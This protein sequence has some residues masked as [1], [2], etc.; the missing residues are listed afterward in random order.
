MSMM[1]QIGY[2]GVVAAQIGLNTTAQNIAN[3][4]TPG[5]S[6]L[7]TV[8]GSV[9]GT[10]SQQIG[11]GVVVNAVRRMS[12]DFKTQQVWRATTDMHYY[13]A[14]QD[15]LSSLEGVM[16]GEGSNISMGL[17]NFYAALSAASDRPADIPL[18]QQILAEMKNLTQRFNGLN[19]NISN[20]LD[21]LHE[22][23]SAMG[24]EINGLANNLA[25][26][27]Q[28]IVEAESTGGDSAS[29]RDHREL[30][31][32]ELS[33]YTD[34]RVNEARDGS[35][36]ISMPNGQ[37]LVAGNTAGQLTITTNAAG[38]QE[39]ALS[40]AGTSFPLR[41]D[42]LGGAFGGLY[43]VEHN[44]LLPAKEQLMEMA[45]A[46]TTMVNDTLAT[47]FD[48]AGNPGQPLLAFNP[49]SATGLLQ[50]SDMK[51]EELAFS[52]K[53][54]E[55]GDNTVLL[56]MI[57]LKN[58]KVTV[59]GNTVTLNEAYSGMLGE[60]ASA[61][62]QNQADFKS[63]VAVAEQAQYQ[64]D[65]V[66][67]VSEAEEAQNMMGYEQAMQANMKVIQTA[68]ELFDTILAAL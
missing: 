37:P 61:S 49:N 41:Q 2:S 39:V 43:D 4:R 29:L 6:R 60:V 36:T 46:L 62:R 57:E 19:T 11:G 5:Y 59:N 64:R 67:G 26:I 66:S 22:Q 23:R 63:A 16:S 13:Q 52:A 32:S 10:S 7:T 35:L 40:F 18:R 1:S 58:K 30:L 31:V 45:G 53:V 65:S 55:P 51:P 54:G 12:D 27:N 17:D 47:G 33:K 34:V 21:A 44:Q 42:S 50:M 3:M 25:L 56:A 48:L 28:K 68:N 14:G 38:Q 24:N 15:Y 8:M 9:A 20:Q